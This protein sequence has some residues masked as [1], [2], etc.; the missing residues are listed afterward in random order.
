MNRIFQRVQ[1]ARNSQA[2]SHLQQPRSRQK[3]RFEA[4]EKRMLLAGDLASQETQELQP[5]AFELANGSR[6]QQQSFNADAASLA[7]SVPPTLDQAHSETTLVFIDSGV[8]DDT[9]VIESI[10]RQFSKSARPNNFQI[11]KLDVDQ[12]P[13][14]SI[15]DVISEQS[16]V[17]S[18]HI[19]SHGSSGRLYL[20]GQTVDAEYLD[21]QQERLHQ[22][23]AFL[24]QDADI[25]LYGCDVAAGHAGI[26]FT[27][28]LASL[29]MRDVAASTNPTGNSGDWILEHRTGQIES[30]TLAMPLTYKG[31][32]GKVSFTDNHLTIDA[33]DGVNNHA[34]RLSVQNNQLSITDPS[35]GDLDAGT[36]ITDLDSTDH[37]VTVAW[38]IH[39]L[40]WLDIDGIENVMIANS[41]DLGDAS[42]EIDA[43]KIEV[44]AGSV[45]ETKGNVTLH[46]SDDLSPLS[47]ANLI[48]L[49]V[50]EASITLRSKLRQSPSTQTPTV[51]TCS[52]THQPPAKSL[53]QPLTF[54]QVFRL[55]VALRSQKRRQRLTYLGVRRSRQRNSQFTLMLL[56]RRGS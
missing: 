14:A 48:D 2:T 51:R 54:C 43:E 11:V 42:L 28:R 10:T 15:T 9:A 53:S 4:L 20:G 29:T 39:N 56:P 7:T 6:N 16:D 37:S 8:H 3:L 49:S 47:N 41:I 36:G 50:T 33:S 25:I 24:S 45:V 35:F 26:S 23:N 12:D 13:F 44:H 5:T 52:P 1:R 19:V 18:L 22:W 46:A 21:S 32:L 27:S 40:S 31:T 34:L 17:S 30:M 55:S 38:P